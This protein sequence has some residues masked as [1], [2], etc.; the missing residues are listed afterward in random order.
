MIS[1][2]LKNLE[3]EYFNIIN[4]ILRYLIE[5]WDWEIIFRK[6]SKL[7]LIDYYNLN[8]AKNHINKKSTLR[9][10][11]ILNREPISYKLKKQVMIASSLTKAE[12]GAFDIVI[13]KVI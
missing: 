3:P 7:F 4:Q 10:I 6:K 9:F 5:S 13:H 11:F 2:F 12:Y 8:W 1:Y